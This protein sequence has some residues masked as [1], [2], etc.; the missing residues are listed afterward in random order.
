VLAKPICE[1][2]PA[3]RAFCRCG[4]FQRH[5]VSPA[6]GIPSLWRAARFARSSDT[7]GHVM[8]DK[9]SNEAAE[10]SSLGDDNETTRIITL[11]GGAAV[12]WPLAALAQPC[13][14]TG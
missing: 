10:F 8:V 1:V 13:T 5:K 12:R 7:V 14:S 11:F 2:L 9:G 4:L 3:I 6:L